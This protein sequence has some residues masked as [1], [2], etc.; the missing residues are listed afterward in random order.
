MIKNWLKDIWNW[1]KSFFNEQ[2]GSSTMRAMCWIWTLTFC[3]CIIFATAFNAIK[4]HEAKL[5][6]IDN[7][8]IIITG[9]FMGSK[10]GQRIWGEKGLGSLGI[11]SP[12]SGSLGS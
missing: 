10:V 1:F 9:I 4:T 2:N 8:Y 6:P 7:A 3:F 11:K 5:P 12:P